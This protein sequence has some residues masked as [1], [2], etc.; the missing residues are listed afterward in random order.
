MK[1]KRSRHMAA[2]VF[3]A[4]LGL[5]LP[6]LGHAQT[7]A[8]KK[9]P[10]KS[11]EALPPKSTEPSLK[12]TGQPTTDPRPQVASLKSDKNQR[13][14]GLTLGF[15]T[16]RALNTFSGSPVGVENDSVQPPVL[17][18]KFGFNPRYKALF[19]PLV[20]VAASILPGIGVSLYLEAGALL[21]WPGFHLSGGV[22]RALIVDPGD[23]QDTVF[24]N[25]TDGAFIRGALP[26]G[27]FYPSLEIR[28]RTVEK[29][30]IARKEGL[31]TYAQHED[32]FLV[33]P[34]LQVDLNPIK[35]QGSVTFYQAGNTAIGSNEFGL[36]LDASQFTIYTVGVGYQF[37]PKM[38][39]WLR[40][41]Q[42]DGIEDE[43]AH[44]YQVPQLY[45][46]FMLAKNS[47]FLEAQW[48][49]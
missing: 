38:L 28:K 15:Q 2:I 19:Q 17:T 3:I 14:R 21:D 36:G 26:L 44:Y 9:T 24:D 41:N 35:L 29:A 8:L 20:N 48:T 10:S 32:D 42:V 16:G 18:G 49:F 12:K 40:A 34:A 11:A 43:T 39:M 30:V 5:S 6:G 1:F 23:Y 45:P 33:R 37:T 46:D 31:P 13:V 25:S 7:K 4:T 27:R 22:E 47:F